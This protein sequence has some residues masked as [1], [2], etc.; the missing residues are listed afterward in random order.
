MHASQCPPPTRPGSERVIRVGTRSS[1]EGMINECAQNTKRYPTGIRDIKEGEVLEGIVYHEAPKPQTGMGEVG[2][3]RK[4]KV[5]WEK[6]KMTPK[7]AQ[8]CS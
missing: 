2:T 4:M 7:K 8:W 3:K 6:M 1:G 5:R